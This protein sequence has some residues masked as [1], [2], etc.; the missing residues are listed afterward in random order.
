[1]QTRRL[2][3][4]GFGDNKLPVLFFRKLV[5]DRVILQRLLPNWM[6]RHRQIQVIR[7]RFGR[8]YDASAEDFTRF[9]PF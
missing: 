3:F 5:S 8:K 6:E 4:I 2:R 1:M 9:T 7:S